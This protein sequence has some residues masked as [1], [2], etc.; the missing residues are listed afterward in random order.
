MDESIAKLVEAQGKVD[1][2]ERELERCRWDRARVV[3][4]A[5]EQMTLESIGNC[6]GLSKQAVAGILKQRMEELS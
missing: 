1:E 5:R 3:V 6:L 4:A 2:A